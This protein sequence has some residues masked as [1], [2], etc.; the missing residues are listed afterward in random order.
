MLR[1]EKPS[2]R[3]SPAVRSTIADVDPW[4]GETY[5]AIARSLPTRAVDVHQRDC[6]AWTP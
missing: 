2:L 1:P 3:P 4:L 5:G 6:L